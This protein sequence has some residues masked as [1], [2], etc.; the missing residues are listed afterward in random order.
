MQIALTR[1]LRQ[2]R[3]TRV[4]LPTSADMH[5]DH[6]IVHEELMI[7]LFH[8]QGRIWPELGEPTADVPRVYELAVYCD[9]P[10]PPQ[11]RLKT[12]ESMFENKLRAIS[13]YGSQ[14][15]IGT[16]VDI[17]RASGPVEYLRELN[18]HFYDPQQYHELFARTT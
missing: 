9:F 18:F 3:P 12:P 4:F 13:T 2:V 11:I 16:V 15:Q 8:A 1:L 17:Q 5:P 6:R 7:S 14:E 10:E